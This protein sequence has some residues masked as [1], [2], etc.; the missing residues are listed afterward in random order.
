[1][2]NASVHRGNGNRVLTVFAAARDV[3]KQAV[4]AKSC[5]PVLPHFQ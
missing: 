4:E 5:Q 2:Y 3:T 1:V